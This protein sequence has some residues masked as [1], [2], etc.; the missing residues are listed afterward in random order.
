[1]K[2]KSPCWNYL[3]PS[4]KLLTTAVAAV[5][6]CFQPH[7]QGTDIA[8]LKLYGRWTGTPTNYIMGR[9]TTTATP[10]SLAT[11]EAWILAGVPLAS[12][13]GVSQSGAVQV[14][15]AVTGAWVRKL[16]PPATAAVALSYFGTSCAVSGSTAVIGAPGPTASSPGA[17][18]VYNL[19]TGA[20]LK[21]LK[22]NPADGVNG[23]FFGMS[24]AI[25]GNRVVVG[26]YKDDSVRGSAYV[27]DLKTGAQLA[28]FLDPA[29]VA[30]DQFGFSCAVEGNV[31]VIGA[32]GADSSRGAAYAYDLTSLVFIK[33]YQPGA[34]VA[35][36]QAGWAVAMHQGKI[37]LGAPYA[38]GSI[39]KIFVMGLMDNTA[40]TLTAS[41]AVVGEFIGRCVSTHQGLLIAGSPYQAGGRGAIYLYDLNSTATTEFQKVLPPDG[42]SRYFGHNVSICGNQAVMLAPYDSTQASSAGAAYVMQPIMRPM[43]LTKVAAKADFAPGAVDSSFGTIGDAFMNVNGAVTFASTTTGPGSNGSK[44]TGI[45]TTMNASVPLN[46]MLKSRM[47]DP[48][49]SLPLVSVSAPLANIASTSI[50]R[51]IL[52]GTGVSALN[53][54]AIY[55]GDGTTFTRILRAGDA[56]AAFSGAAL[57]SF[58]QVVQSTNVNRVATTCALRQNVGGTL[59]SND[60]GLL[61]YDVGGG[62]S[63]AQREGLSPT[64][65]PALTY[66]QFSG[67]VAAYWSKATYSTA[68]TGATAFNQAIFQKTYGGAIVKVVQKGGL[69]AGGSGAGYSSF[70][71]ESSDDTNERV[72]F[73]ATLGAPATAANNEGLWMCVTPG[74][75]ASDVRVMRKGDFVPGLPGVKIAK[76]IQFSQVYSSALALVQLSGTGVTAANDQALLVLRHDGSLINDQLTVLLREG[77]PAP[78]CGAAT[79]G[80]IN[81]V[82]LEPYFA[83]YMVL[84]T[85]VGAPAGT[86]LVL[87][88]GFA[89]KSVGSV[90]EKTLIRPVPVLRKGQLF[91]N[92]PS[93]ITSISL[94]TTSF[95]ASGAGNTGLGLAMRQ[96][97]G[98]STPNT[99][100]IAVDFSNGV[101]QV[102][103]GI[104]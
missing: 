8:T 102:M 16:Q 95:T 41:D 23:D 94:P 85:L 86:D 38:A 58:T 9:D 3:H 55:K 10:N 82:A 49:G 69:D 76:F 6:A 21:T 96:T 40:L 84:T 75:S 30:N 81:R 54:Q 28:K 78:G 27:F 67:R 60:S 61:W 87:F 20:L 34:S 25:S 37:I 59:A 99:V 44:D 65:F 12:D 72:L 92:Q 103:Q 1:M 33:K 36:D 43:P 11:N 50:F 5:I 31:A 18:Y 79:I 62:T 52:G 104:P 29:S 47:I 13:Q 56:A 19:A 35:N 73:R 98:S 83:Q 14:F 48:V 46:L 39:G 17:A 24:V 64:G 100:V 2:M 66:G 4:L 77:D 97:A 88:R 68:L 90:A 15:N 42:G 91:A 53:N 7:A 70:L 71:G 80:T 26:A 93:K 57:A 101:H 45:W 51:G 63:E 74:T 32:P 89:K 22:P